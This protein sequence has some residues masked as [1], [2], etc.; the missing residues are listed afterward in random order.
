[1]NIRPASGKVAELF[2]S[3]LRKPYPVRN[4]GL[5]RIKKLDPQLALQIEDALKDGFAVYQQ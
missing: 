4:L 2:E 1:M 3:D 5:D